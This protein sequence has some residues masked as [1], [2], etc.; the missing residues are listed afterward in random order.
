M[1]KTTDLRREI[2]TIFVPAM[3]R[4]GFTVDKRDLPVFLR[5]WRIKDDEAHLFDIQWEKY[6][7][8]R[9]IVNFGRCPAAGLVIRGKHYAP[10]D[11][12]ASWTPEGG[13]LQPQ[14]GTSSRS[15]FR[16]DKPFLQSLFSREKLRPADEVIAV[17]LLCTFGEV[18]MW[19]ESRTRMAHMHRHLHLRQH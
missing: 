6:G 10:Q 19:W 12:L 11:V 1:G 9:F 16:Q 8:P 13:R 4:R 5:F 2:T 17:D 14:P 3:Q 7:R 18:E 15:W